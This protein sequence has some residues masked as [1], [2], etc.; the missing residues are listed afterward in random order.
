MAVVEVSEDARVRCQ[1]EGCG[2]SVY[3]RIHVVYVDKQFMV[4]GSQ[5]YQRLFRP[6]STASQAPRYGASTGRVLTAEERNELIENTSAFIARL[7]AERAELERLAAQQKT[8]FAAEQKRLAE[9]R[10]KRRQAALP[11]APVHV[12]D[13]ERSPLYEGPN[14]LRWRWKAAEV[15]AACLVDHSMN[16][17]RSPHHATVAAHVVRRPFPS[18][19]AFALDVELKARL[20]KRYIF[21]ALDELGM[22]GMA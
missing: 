21:R 10:Q 17:S 4:L 5:C 11:P 9:L 8:R 3:K 7:E 20:P 22:I 2:H 19:Y 1:A 13:D 14:M 16:P 12:A 18:P 6:A 15:I